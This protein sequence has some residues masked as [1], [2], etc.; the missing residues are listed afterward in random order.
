MLDSDLESDGMQSAD[1]ANLSLQRLLTR[2]EKEEEL[3][4]YGWKLDHVA[5]VIYRVEERADLLTQL[6]LIYIHI[7]HFVEHVG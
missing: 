2:L 1:V 3:T 7:L 5:Q 6:C 4:D